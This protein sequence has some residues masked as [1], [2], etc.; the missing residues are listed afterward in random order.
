MIVA[1]DGMPFLGSMD[2]FADA[3]SMAAFQPELLENINGPAEEQELGAVQRIFF[4]CEGSS[5]DFYPSADGLTLSIHSQEVGSLR[6]AGSSVA[7][8]NLNKA[9]LGL[10][11]IDSFFD[12]VVIWDDIVVDST[13]KDCDDIALAVGKMGIAVNA[14]LGELSLK[15]WAVM[16]IDTESQLLAAYPLKEGAVL[17]CILDKSAHESVWRRDIPAKLER[18]Q[19]NLEL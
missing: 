2:T 9:L 18:I 12:A 16:V 13:T 4:A 10:T 19:E 7:G 14:Y 8:D 5:F 11:V 15:P 6:Y 1:D 3:E 17:V